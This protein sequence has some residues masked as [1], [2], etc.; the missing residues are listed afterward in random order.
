MHERGASTIVK[1]FSLS[2]LA[3]G[4]LLAAIMAYTESEPGAIPLVLISLGVIGYVTA[5]L[6]SRKA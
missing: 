6:K 4:A 1:K 5:L 2:I 3:A